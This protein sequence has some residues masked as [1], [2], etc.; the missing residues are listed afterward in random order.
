LEFAGYAL[1]AF[2]LGALHALEPGHGKTVVAAYLVGER[3]RIRDAVLL[4]IVVTLAHTSSVIILA[5]LA[6]VAAER[7]VPERVH[8]IMEL[9]AGVIVLAVGIGMLV[10][11]K[12]RLGDHGHD[13]SEH[14]HSHGHHHHGHDHGAVAT[15]PD[16]RLGVTGLVALGISGGIVPCPAAFAILIA[17][18]GLA[19]FARGV[20]LVAIFS[21]GMAAVLIA[22]GIAMVRASEAM[23]SRLENNSRFV[24]I[25]PI[26]SAVLIALIGAV[27]IVRALHHLGML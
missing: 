16:G 11:R 5:F 4:G 20:G 15:G 23:K 17:A 12:R 24:Q 8:E 1:S 26:I 22:V 19:E 9:V 6:T 3:G 18:V 25:V 10:A 21:M 2:W 13:H 7:F 14:G 27:L